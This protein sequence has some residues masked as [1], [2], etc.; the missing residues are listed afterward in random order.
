MLLRFPD[1]G[2]S[3]CKSVEFDHYSRPPPPPMT[4]ANPDSKQRAAPATENHTP[5]SISHS[6]R[7]S[8]DPGQAEPLSGPRTRPPPPRRPEINSQ[9]PFSSSQSE[10]FSHCS[11]SINTNS[12]L[13]TSH[14]AEEGSER[15]K[16]LVDKGPEAVQ[17][18][19]TSNPELESSP[20][21]PSGPASMEGQR[22]PSPQ[23]FPQRLSDK[24]PVFAQ[25]EVS[26]R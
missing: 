13:V 11:P 23:F 14:T 6:P 24:P 1:R 15:G 4:G 2:S 16:R 5:T 20:L 12:A 19:S 9:E 26:N 21:A 10:V 25:E 8:K 3:D 17:H 18:L 7:G 22:S